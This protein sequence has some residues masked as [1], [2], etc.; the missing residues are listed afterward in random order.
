MTAVASYSVCPR[1]GKDISPIADVATQ[2]HVEKCLVSRPLINLR[3]ACCRP[4][5][6]LQRNVNYHYLTAVLVLG[7]HDYN[8]LLARELQA[9]V[10]GD[11]MIPRS[12]VVAFLRLIKQIRH[13]SL[14]QS[15]ELQ[16]Q[17]WQQF[18]ATFEQL[19]V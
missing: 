6:L 4:E 9:V 11:D 1:T 5:H 13:L 10:L 18:E 19:Q 3:S 7:R 2:N 14:A 16:T 12:S 17:A 15:E 8:S